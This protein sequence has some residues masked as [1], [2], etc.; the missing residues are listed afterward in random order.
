MIRQRVCPK[1]Y[2]LFHLSITFLVNKL[3]TH[4]KLYPLKSGTLL[5]TPQTSLIQR[6]I[7]RASRCPKALVR[8]GASRVLL[9]SKHQSVWS[10]QDSQRSS[11]QTFIQGALLHNN[12]KQITEQMYLGSQF[13]SQREQ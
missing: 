12:W 8:A 3:D 2:T 10:D 11:C 7:V 6:D 4:D 5:K 9:L 13:K 1:K